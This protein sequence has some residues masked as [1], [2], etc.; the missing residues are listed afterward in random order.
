MLN[1]CFFKQT[2][3][4]GRPNI[5]KF[6]SHWLDPTRNRTSS[7]P[8]YEADALSTRSTYKKTINL[9]KVCGTFTAFATPSGAP[10]LEKETA[11]IFSPR[12]LQTLTVFIEMKHGKKKPAIVVSIR[13]KALRRRRRINQPTSIPFEH[14]HNAKV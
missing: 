6:V 13:F 4:F 1:S 11:N 2:L 5:R 14:G 9:P 3:R 12:S 7:L 10:P 8:T